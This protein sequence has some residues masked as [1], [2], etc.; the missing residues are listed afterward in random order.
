MVSMA[1]IPQPHH[2]TARFHHPPHHHAASNDHHDGINNNQD[3]DADNDDDNRHT[4]DESCALASRRQLTATQRTCICS[5][6]S[7]RTVTDSHRSPSS[8]TSCH[9]ARSRVSSNPPSLTSSLSSTSSTPPD[10]SKLPHS[11][12]GL[13]PVRRR[14]RRSDVRRCQTR[15]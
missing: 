12:K 6:S 14:C 15:C 10:L 9:A 4:L 11:G 7:H 1:I 3:T 5:P 8:G 2:I 13:Q